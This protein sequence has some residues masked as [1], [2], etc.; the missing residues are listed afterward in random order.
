[1]TNNPNELTVTEICLCQSVLAALKG[2]FNVFFVSDCS[3]GIT[4]Q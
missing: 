2:G 1:M 3:G 4:T